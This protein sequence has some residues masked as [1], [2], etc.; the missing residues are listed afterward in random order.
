[1]KESTAHNPAGLVGRFFAPITLRQWAVPALIGIS[2]IPFVAAYYLI[3]E[4]L[5]LDEAQSLWQTSRSIGGVLA[6]VAGDVHV[7]LYHLLLYVW[8]L[9]IGDG[10]ETA[11]LLSLAFFLLSLPA[12]YALGNRAYAAPVGLF[13]ALLLAIS[14]FM[15][16][17]ANEIRMYTLFVFITIVNQY[18]FLRLFEKEKPSDT[19]WAFYALSAVFG[20]F[21]HYFFF[22]NLAAQTVFYALRRTLFPQ[23]AFRRFATVA[24]LVIAALVPWVWYVLFRGVVGFQEPVLSPPSSVNLFSTFS[25]FLFGF[26]ND[27]LNTIFLSL[28]P[29][30][31]ILGLIALRRR[32]RFLPQT[33]YFALTILISFGV[34][35]FISYFIAPVFVGRYLIFTVPSLYLLVISL[36]SSYAR[37]VR[38]FAQWSLVALMLVALGVQA[39]HPNTSVK[40]WYESAATYLAT[41]ATAQDIILV[42]A[43]FTVYPIQYYYRGPAPIATLPSWDQYAYGPIPAFNEATLPE[44]VERATSSYQNVYVLLS[45]DQGYEET[46]RRYFDSNYQRLAIQN[47]SNDL[48]LYVYRLRYNTERS[49]IRA[50][51]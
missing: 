49:V 1:M 16:W 20:M 37:N 19:I 46:I 41:R 14:P 24:G 22:L 12:I 7:P 34:A 47:F 28:W 2:F 26:Q 42:S 45:Y 8:R 25:Q 27:L 21:T 36:F 18:L 35:F 3:G 43:P 50:E 10:I 39:I 29:L 17:Y 51:L 15:N 9:F 13:A 40:E 31:V 38:L 48:T 30:A 33:E 11:R 5:R 6:I 44:E 23:G 32:E 4:S